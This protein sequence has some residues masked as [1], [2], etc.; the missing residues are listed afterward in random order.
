MSSYREKISNRIN[1]FEANKVFSTNDFLDI[2]SNA[3]V[4]HIWKRL[5]DV[6]FNGKAWLRT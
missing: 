3:T 1:S 5:K 2:A 6:R 4:R